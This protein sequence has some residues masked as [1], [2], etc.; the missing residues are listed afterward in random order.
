VQ[1]LVLP[2]WDAAWMRDSGIGSVGRPEPLEVRVFGTLNTAGPFG[3]VMVVLLLIAL[4]TRRI[5]TRVKVLATGLALVA[6]GLSLVRA[7]WLA[8]LLAVVLLVVAR[9]LPLARVV[10]GSVALALLLAV[11]GGP[12]ADAI[13]NR[14]TETAEAGTQ[15]DSLGDRVAFQAS[16]APQALRDVVGQGLGSAGIASRLADDQASVVTS[17]DSGIFE[18]L[19]TLGSIP[20]LALLATAATVA[21]RSFRRALRRSAEEA[22]LAAP[23]VG[24]VAGLVFT[25]TFAGVYGVCLWVLAG[26]AGRAETEW[27]VAEAGGRTA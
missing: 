5:S 10:G 24:L 23:L 25:N 22:F 19:Y 9:R 2:D 21:V 16:V 14:A 4:G 27:P 11:A 26:F 6:I 8:L 17:F 18:T 7:A 3:Q 20:G 1:Y 13:T 15:D 12:V